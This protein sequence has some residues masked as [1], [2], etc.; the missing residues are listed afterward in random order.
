MVRA[1][2]TYHP[3]RETP[4]TAPRVI[5]GAISGNALAAASIAGD[6]PAGWYERLPDDP[7]GWRSRAERVRD[8]HS[9]DWLEKLQPAINAT[10]KARERLEA[11]GA[12]TG[13]VVTT[14]QQP[15]LFG[16]PVYTLSKALSALALADSLQAATGIPV[17]PIFWA[18]TDDTDFKEASTTAISLT[19][20]AQL[21]RMEPLAPIGLPMASMPFG[22]VSAQLQALA[23][24]AGSAIDTTPLELLERCYGAT[25]TVGSAYVS[26]LRALMAPLGIAVLDASHLATRAAAKAVLVQ[27]LEHAG[28]IATALRTRN[29]EIEAAGYSPQV[30]EVPGLSLVFD[31]TPVGRKRI[32]IKGA[33]KQAGSKELGP[34]VLLRPVVER[35]ILP[36]VTYIGGAAEIAYFA[37]L[38][39]IAEILGIPKP[40]ILPRWSCTIIEPH[41]ERILNRLRLAPDD[42]RD[43]HEAESRVAR[44]RLPKRVFNELE[45]LRAAVDER[46]NLLAEAI[47]EEGAP[48]SGA[49]TDGLRANLL[50]RLDRFE[51]RLVAAAKRRY[52]DVMT[53]IGTVRGSLYPFGKQQERGLN[54]V[55]LLA[56]YGTA[57]RDDMLAQAVVHAAHLLNAGGDRA[58]A[59]EQRFTAQNSP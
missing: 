15:G 53:E 9:R 37:Q 11:A 23:Q 28:E 18:A 22:D 59:T 50:R 49:V 36:T 24:S 58:R 31:K 1:L 26:F 45:R 51:R 21:L 34:N 52:V 44:E 29:E 39:P 38:G 16:G 57:L 47:A 46:A 2:S 41:V 5:T 40:A 17:A 35:A 10:G 25:E 20:G 42:F 33:A 6:A 32:P 48:V 54:F 12:G 55:P 13:I 43:P 8:S 56:R 30:Q 27:A 14:G 4:L 7:Q 19:G 3:V